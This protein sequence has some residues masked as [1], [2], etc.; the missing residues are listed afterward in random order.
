MSK[1][2][3]ILIAAVLAG[4]LMA[5]AQV[6]SATAA[7]TTE[8]S[9]LSEKASR[10]MANR[11]WLNAS[12]MYTLMSAQRPDS[13]A[14]YARNITAL[15]MAGQHERALEVF[16]AAFE[17]GLPLDSLLST[18]QTESRNAGRGSIYPNM[19]L[20]ARERYPWMART[21]DLSLLDY[22]NF[23]DNAPKI[24]EY[25]RRM[26]AGKPGD[27]RFNALLARGYLLDG[28]PM[29]AVGVWQ[30]I[31]RTE[32]DNLDALLWTGNTLAALGKASEARPYL[33]R[34][35]QLRPTPYLE[36]ILFPKKNH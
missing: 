29:M 32:P 11:E 33:E 25:A 12:A 5:S 15:D 21:F 24:V 10:F 23:T 3:S 13:V 35:Y 20:S 22:Y 36:K 8:Y 4:S 16:G 2:L 6:Y 17:H 1:A 18:I 9:R 14:V 7:D 31:L 34:A 27:T 19:L 30:T 26:L 28:R